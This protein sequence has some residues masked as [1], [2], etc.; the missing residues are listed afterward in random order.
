MNL[1]AG[2]AMVSCYVDMAAFLVM[3]VLMLFSGRMRRRN[4]ASL[5]VFT[6]LCRCV[7]ALCVLCFVFHAMYRQSAPWCH[8]A[9]LIS[10]TLWEGLILV[11]VFLWTAYI[12]SELYE[13]PKAHS[14]WYRLLLIPLAAFMVLLAVNLF[15]GHMFTVN[16]ENTA[17]LKPLF[18]VMVA[19]ELAYFAVSAIMVRFYDRKPTKR[20]FLRVLPML[21]SLMA[22]VLIQYFIAYDTGILGFAIG[23]LLLYFS[24]A[25]KHRLTDEESGLYN[26]GFLACLFDQALAGKDDIGSVLILEADGSLPAAFRI[27]ND[28]LHRT[29]DVIRVEENKF[30]MFAREANRTALQYQT[31]LVDEAV[32]KHNTAHPEEK[33]HITARCRVRAANEDCFAF[34]RTVLDDKEAGDEMRGV[35]SM[36]S[37]LDRLDKELALAAD[38]QINMLPMV[39]PPFPDRR[40]FDLFASMTPAKEVGGDFY[41]FFLI[42]A[43]HLAL[44]IADVS[45]KG[46]P[47]AL[48]M[49]VSKTLIKNQLMAGCDPAAAMERV[50]QQLCEHNSAMMFV[51]V[52]LAVLEISTGRGTACNAG[53]ENPCLRRAGGDFEMLR[54]RHG[55]FAGASRKA[56][57]E[58]REFV[59]QPGDSV[60]VYTD[61]VP[62][63]TDAAMAMFGTERLTGTLNRDADADPETLI[64]G[65]HEAVNGFV[66][67]AP[68]FDDITMLC[69]KY[70]GA[71]DGRE[72]D[73]EKE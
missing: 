66:Q 27:L 31:S 47:A 25:D 33:V 61:G 35:V 14:A 26:R 10:K 56:K 1:I 24:A 68:Q 72:K 28:T 7:T 67:G 50:N 70:H 32:E 59:L 62:E 53:H 63:A 44:V 43:D 20:R 6:W 17:E 3:V 21:V 13:K 30:M 55:I 52:W 73:R 46:I 65:M 51:T 9:A 39:F 11:I 42:D 8:P 49:M 34:I 23:I 5:R 2:S 19:A 40:E 45:G 64:R 69:L 22:M 16:E 48:F 54:Y 38:I 58:N 29:G 18:Y 41:D 71:P 60:F 12:N 15:T 36:M 4:T 57:Y 37:E